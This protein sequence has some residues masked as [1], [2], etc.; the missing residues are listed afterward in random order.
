MAH[1][2][3]SSRSKS[4]PHSTRAGS[5]SRS[6]RTRGESHATRGRNNRRT[7]RRSGSGAVADGYKVGPGHP[8]KEFQFKKG[9]S[10]N[11]KGRHRKKSVAADLV[12]ALEE[13]VTVRQGDR[14]RVLT[15][16]QAGVEQLVNQF[17]NGDRH[18]RRDLLDLVAEVG[19]DLIGA[20]S[21][22][23][24]ETIEAAVTAND[25]AL[26]AGFV[27]RYGGEFDPSDLESNAA[28]VSQEVAP[29]N[30]EEKDHDYPPNHP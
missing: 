26:V 5:K 8:P 9:Q 15:K 1:K 24:K 19:L 16:R 18:A 28:Q 4:K 30:A 7:G 10:G 13:K 17:A 21:E 22:G 20:E 3:R 25:L 11:P 14:A 2:R 27:R 29:E 12:R 23:I 6:T